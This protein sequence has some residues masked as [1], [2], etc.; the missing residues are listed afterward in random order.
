M[1]PAEMQF[2]RLYV[3]T[4]RREY[5]LLRSVMDLMSPAG[6][7]LKSFTDAINAAVALDDMH[8]D[9]ETQLSKIQ[10]KNNIQKIN[11]STGPSIDELAEMFS[12]SFFKMITVAD[13]PVAGT[14]V[15][16]DDGWFS[17][18]PTEWKKTL[19]LV[20]STPKDAGYY[21]PD[22][23]SNFFNTLLKF[24]PFDK[25]ANKWDEN[26]FGPTKKLWPP[27]NKYK[28]EDAQYFDD[29][30][31]DNGMSQFDMFFDPEDE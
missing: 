4:L 18:K 24:F 26:L 19:E 29:D 10:K 15:K 12:L 28:D 2:I 8:A 31:D 17:G 7:G 13:G 30:D 1:S 3:V 5:Y 25:P 27:P 14:T 23:L 11:V 6:L 22:L 20:K 21:L 16:N 9:F